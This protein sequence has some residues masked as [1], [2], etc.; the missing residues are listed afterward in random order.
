MRFQNRLLTR[1]AP[2]QSHDRK[3]VV[4]V[5]NAQH[6]AVEDLVGRVLLLRRIELDLDGLFLAV[7]AEDFAESLV[8]FGVDLNLDVALR[9]TGEADLALLVGPRF[10]LRPDV[11]AEAGSGVFG[12]GL[13]PQDDLG[14]VDW[15]AGQGRDDDL[16]LGFRVGAQRDLRQSPEKQRRYREGAQKKSTPI[17]HTSII[18]PRW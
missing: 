12:V 6:H 1:A 8:A 14:A 15:P 17:P 18:S 16:D 2:I 11:P 9:H 10:K 5:T 3:G 13:P 4:S 7:D